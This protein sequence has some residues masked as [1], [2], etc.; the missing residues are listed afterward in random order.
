MEL[1]CK[2]VCC[3]NRDISF[4][5]E[6][7]EAV[8]AEL[9]ASEEA[10]DKNI[11]EVSPTII[12]CSIIIPRTSCYLCGAASLISSITTINGNIPIMLST[13]TKERAGVLNG[14]SDIK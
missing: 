11:R 4:L 7:A 1:E 3:G 13:G 8:G 10:V 9:R 12:T 2:R 14:I 6:I 5:S